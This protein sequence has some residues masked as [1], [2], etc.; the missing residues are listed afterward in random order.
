MDHVK[1]K[2]D[3]PLQGIRVKEAQAAFLA[4]AGEFVDEKKIVMEG[5]IKSRI[6]YIGEEDIIHH[7]EEDIPFS[8]LIKT[9]N[10]YGLTDSIRVEIVKKETMIEYSVCIYNPRIDKMELSTI[11]RFYLNIKTG[12]RKVDTLEERTL[13]TTPLSLELPIENTKK[14]VEKKEEVFSLNELVTEKID[15]DKESLKCE[16]EKEL[17]ARMNSLSSNSYFF[18]RIKAMIKK[19]MAAE[20]QKNMPS[21]KEEI[22]A[23]LEKKQLLLNEEKKDQ[24]IRKSIEQKKTGY[25]SKENQITIN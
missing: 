11:L 18:K 17:M 22:M 14:E 4:V 25:R 6:T 10:I 13:I 23:M 8:H 12:K 24:L 5:V 20:I 7:Y 21:L 19:E 3:N 2:R 16:L 9:E 15:T 1:A